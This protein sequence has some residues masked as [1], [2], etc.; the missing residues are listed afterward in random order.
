MNK[1][2]MKLQREKQEDVVLNKVLWWI[3]GAVVLE[4]LLLLLNR[5]YTYYT[6]AGIGLAQAL[7]TAF[8]VL[9]VVLPICFVALLVWYRAARKS[10][11]G[12]RLSGAL[13]LVALALAVCAV[14]VALFGSAGIQLL[15]VAVPA[16]AALALIY[17]LYQHEF[18][19]VAVLSALGLLGVHLIPR[20]D[21]STVAAYGYGVALLVILVAVLLLARRLQTGNGRLSLGGKPVD[22]LPQNA[23]YALIY[24]TCGVVAAVTAAAFL[25]GA[26]ALLYGVLVAWLLI[27]AVYYTVRLM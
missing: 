7:R 24:A 17:Y 4:F 8:K 6:P 21:I 2:E 20:A 11:R 5:A 27:M 1:K 18:F 23:N 14:V 12:T 9:A 22:L 13:T 16:V 26:L 19:L 3:V 10:G 15:Y 25:M